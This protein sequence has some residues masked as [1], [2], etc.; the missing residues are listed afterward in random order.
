MRELSF[1]WNV[2]SYS[3]R[4]DET[5]SIIKKKLSFNTYIPIFKHCKNLSEGFKYL[6]KNDIGTTTF[7][8]YFE[9]R[10]KFLI[11]KKKK[12]FKI[13]CIFLGM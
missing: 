5:Y 12:S 2:S 8:L 9:I 13:K 1:S 4:L 10:I 11:E 7:A 3:F 6:E